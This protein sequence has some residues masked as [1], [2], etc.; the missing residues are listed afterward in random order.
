MARGQFGLGSRGGALGVGAGL[1]SR[2]GVRS[3]LYHAA[4]D[5]WWSVNE[6]Q[7]VGSVSAIRRSESFSDGVKTVELPAVLRRSHRELA[8]RSWR[9]RAGRKRRRSRRNSVRDSRWGLGFG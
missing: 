8:S 5:A 1:T 7:F 3:A 6:N 2:D 4:G 9:N